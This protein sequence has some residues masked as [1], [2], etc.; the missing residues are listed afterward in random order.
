ME[1]NKMKGNGF[2]K[3]KVNGFNYSKIRTVDGVKYEGCYW[4]KLL[5]ENV[6]WKY[7]IWP[8]KYE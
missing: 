4:V 6:W 7:L 5:M 1:V 2:C 3:W 8:I